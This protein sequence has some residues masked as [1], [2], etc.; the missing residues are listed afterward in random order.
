MTP[1]KRYKA[2]PEGTSDRQ[3]LTG[4]IQTETDCTAKA[5]NDTLN[6]LIGTITASLKKNKKVQLVGFGTFNVA[7]RAARKGRNPQTGDVIKIK[8]SKSGRK[9]PGE[10]F[11]PPSGACGSSSI[12]RPVAVGT[13]ISSKI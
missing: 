10:F 11:C 5:A 1:V 2:K 9:V 3:H 7:K 12:V 6:A 13:V 8:A 4:V